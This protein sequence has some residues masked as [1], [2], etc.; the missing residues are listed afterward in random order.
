[1]GASVLLIR[2]DLI[3]RRC[4]NL[5]TPGDGAPQISGGSSVRRN[6]QRWRRV[7]LNVTS[8]TR[9]QPGPNKNRGV[10][11]LVMRTARLMFRRRFSPSGDL[12]WLP[13][14]TL[15]VAKA[16]ERRESVVACNHCRANAEL[17]VAIANPKD[18]RTLRVFRCECGKLTS[19]HD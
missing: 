6:Q 13:H 10:A 4:W 12:P 5:V 11:D 19:R 9:Y 3:F 14:M 8:V 7:G 2:I 16:F 1:M 17:I 15:Q 18:G